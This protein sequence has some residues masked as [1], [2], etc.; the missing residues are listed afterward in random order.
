MT[1]KEYISI[2]NVAFGFFL[3]SGYQVIRELILRRRSRMMLRAQTALFRHEIE[4]SIRA[5][6][7]HGKTCYNESRFSSALIAY[8]SFPF[9]RA[10]DFSALLTIQSSM[11]EIHDL[12]AEH[13]DRHAEVAKLDRIKGHYEVFSQ[14]ARRF[15]GI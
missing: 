15:F 4:K 12:M 5:G 9:I 10:K 2:I 13:C 8:F 3:A 1:Y 11:G 14:E 6:I 7:I